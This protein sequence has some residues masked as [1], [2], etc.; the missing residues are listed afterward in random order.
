MDFMHDSFVEDT[1]DDYIDPCKIGVAS[2]FVLVR[3]LISSMEKVLDFVREH[4]DPSADRS[5]NRL[6]WLVV[7]R[8]DLAGRTNREAFMMDGEQYRQVFEFLEHM[9]LLRF[10]PEER[11]SPHVFSNAWRF[12]C[13]FER[14]YRAF[15][16]P[17][18][19]SVFKSKLDAEWARYDCLVSELKGM[20]DPVPSKW[21]QTFED[22]YFE[23]GLATAKHDIASIR[24]CMELYGRK[25]YS[26]VRGEERFA[27]LFSFH[28]SRPELLE[29]YEL[30]KELMVDYV[31]MYIVDAKRKLDASGPKKGYSGRLEETVS[32]ARVY[33]AKARA[34]YVKTPDQLKRFERLCES[35]VF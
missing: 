17:D 16:H 23:R 30:F 28:G 9:L 31:P 7:T 13:S 35:I 1:T 20:F 32:N 12:Y 21:S 19:A 6:I 29:Q 34:L 2:K 18:N 3:T 24:A 8:G 33:L 15:V 4:P 14:T 11:A 26:F 5:M 10:T 27:K 22:C 25:T